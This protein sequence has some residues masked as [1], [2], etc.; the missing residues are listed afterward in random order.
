MEHISIGE[1]LIYPAEAQQNGIQ[2]R[3]ICQFV[4]EKDGRVSDVLI[5]RSTGEPSLDKE[6]IRLIQSMPRWKPGM[7]RGKPVRVKYTVPINFRLQ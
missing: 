1:N 2:G 7:Q 3:A 5:I 4:I 6:A